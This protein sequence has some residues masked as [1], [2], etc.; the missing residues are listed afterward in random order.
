[1]QQHDLLSCYHGASV[2]SAHLMRQVN[3]LAVGGQ[4]LRRNLHV[5]TQ[6]QFRLIGDVRLNGECSVMS[7]LTVRFA[8]SYG[9]PKTIDGAIEHDDVVGHVHMAIFVDPL[10]ANHC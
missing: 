3:A 6:K 5:I 4:D 2:G 10:G 1:M 9:C 7:A 8:Q